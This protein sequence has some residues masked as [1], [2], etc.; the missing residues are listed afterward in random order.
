M[1]DFNINLDPHALTKAIDRVNENYSNRTDRQLS[2]IHLRTYLKKFVDAFL[3]EVEGEVG[4][5][6]TLT[7]RDYLTRIRGGMEELAEA[8]EDDTDDD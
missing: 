2:R 5:V 4:E 7:N 3:D 8:M 6:I 1:E